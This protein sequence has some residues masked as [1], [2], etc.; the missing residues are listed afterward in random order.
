MAQ[1]KIY[2]LKNNTTLKEMVTNAITI[3][4]TNSIT[5]TTL[6]A[7]TD[8]TTSESIK[9]SSPINTTSNITTTTSTSNTNTAVTKPGSHINWGDQKFE[10]DPTDEYR[11]YLL[12]KT[13]AIEPDEME[14]DTIR[15]NSAVSWVVP[16]GGSAHFDHD[17]QLIPFRYSVGLKT[18]EPTPEQIA[19]LERIYERPVKIEGVDF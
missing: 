7:I 4:I 3:Y 17:R 2:A 6:T 14:E 18:F 1:A 11:Y 16:K 19:E 5:T 9:S 12:R 8:T 10:D 15:T 13:R